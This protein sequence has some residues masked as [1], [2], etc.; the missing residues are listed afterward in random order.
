MLG[1]SPLKILFTFGVIL[2]VWFA[3]KYAGRMAEGKA[4]ET[5][6]RQKKAKDKPAVEDMTQCPKCGSYVPSSGASACERDNC[7]YPG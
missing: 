1:F 4:D 7:P 5:L 2:V 6:K 3:F